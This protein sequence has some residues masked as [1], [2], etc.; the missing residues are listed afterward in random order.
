MKNNM[1]VKLLGV[2]GATLLWFAQ[3]EAGV[4]YDIY[5]LP[6]YN[7]GIAEVTG[8]NATGESWG[9]SSL[10]VYGSYVHATLTDTLLN[11][12]DLGTLG[13][14]L[15]KAY[16]GNN[17]GQ[18]VG[19]AYNANGWMRPFVWTPGAG[20]VEL[21]TPNSTRGVAN[22]INNRGDVVGYMGGTTAQRPIIW[23]G[24]A[25]RDLGVVNGTSAEPKAVN[26][27]GIAVGWSHVG[28]ARRGVI[29]TTGGQK[30]VLGTFGGVNSEATGIND[31]GIVVGNAE[32]STLNRKQ[33]F[34]THVSAA[35]ILI[36]IVIPGATESW[37]TNVNSCGLVAG[38]AVFGSTRKAFLYDLS[39]SLFIDLT[40]AMK[41][42]QDS[43]NAAGWYGLTDAV[44]VG[45]TGNIVGY[46]IHRN[47]G[48]K[49]FRMDPTPLC[50]YVAEPL[51][52]QSELD[53]LIKRSLQ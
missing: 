15:S 19:L 40:I 37:V 6:A 8:I 3:A 47:G 2:L 12:R 39:R 44:G 32:T 16:G 7:G 38:T 31:F 4:F 51:T 18:V 30:V 41:D 53:A 13:G 50:P 14:T 21:P 25:A 36:P 9:S 42:A 28:G 43:L 34:W 24:G 5:E 17:L 49:P 27:S 23:E 26:N 11:M 33:A 22:A 1:Q 48:R 20:L 45:D 52:C 46:G 10:G 35:Q 29:W